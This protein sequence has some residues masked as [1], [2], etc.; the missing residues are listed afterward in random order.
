[1]I[2]SASVWQ[3]SKI[4]G[5]C[6]I[7]SPLVG[8]TTL[9]VATCSSSRFSWTENDISV[10]GVEGSATMLFNWG[11]ILTGVLSLI[12][13]IGLGKSLRSNRLGQLGMGSLMM[14]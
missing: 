1:M 14:G 13:V 11:L 12:F 2:G 4:A 7:T 3:L 6:G 10:L 8:L 9:V 5:V